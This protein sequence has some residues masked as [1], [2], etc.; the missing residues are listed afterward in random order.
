M[1]PDVFASANPA[2]DA[3]RTVTGTAIATTNNEL[4]MFCHSGKI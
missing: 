4:P 1:R 3:T 2:S